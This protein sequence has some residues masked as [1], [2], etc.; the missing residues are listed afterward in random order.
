MIHLYPQDHANHNK[1]LYALFHSVDF[2][3]YIFQLL[4][5]PCLLLAQVF[6][7]YNKMPVVHL[8]IQNS[9]YLLYIRPDLF[10]HIDNHLHQPCMYL[11]LTLEQSDL[12]RT[13]LYVHHNLALQTEKHMHFFLNHSRLKLPSEILRFHSVQKL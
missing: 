7:A 5:K 9:L 13:H 11:P 3:L 8:S 12:Q 4:L 6:H 1:A 2:P 10:L